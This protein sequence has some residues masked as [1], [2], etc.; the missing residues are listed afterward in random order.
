VT[1]TKGSTADS[2]TKLRVNL[3]AAGYSP[4]PA[5]GKSTNVAGW[6]KKTGASP[7][8]IT[9]W[10]K[11]YADHNNTGLI[12]THTP[13]LDIDIKDEAAAAAV[14]A[15]VRVRYGHRDKVLVR[16]GQAPKLLIPFQ[17]SATF[18][19]ITASVI[20][21]DGDTGQKIE[22]L[23]EG[24]MFVA[25]GTH[26]DTGAPYQW[27][28]GEPGSVKC[29]ELPEITQVQARQLVD[30]VV[31]LLCDKFGYSS[32]RPKKNN[33]VNEAA[34]GVAGWSELL[35]SIR[36]GHE[37]HD[38]T[39]DLAAKLVRSGMIGGAAVNVLRSLMDAS[40]APHDKRWQE[41]YD[42]I[43]RSVSSAEKKFKQDAANELTVEPHVFPDEAS[44]ERW[45]FLYDKHLL[46]KTVSGTAAMG[47]TGKSSL[48]MVEALALASGKELLGLKVPRQSRVLLINLEDT[49]NAMD[50]RIA[51]AMKHHGLTVEDI[52]GRLFTKAKGE[53]AFKIAEQSGAGSITP[54][55]VFID[56]LLGIVKSN[57]IDVI[58]ID[59][60]VST[61]AVNENDNSAIRDV[62]ECY[63]H[64]AERGNCAVHLWHHTR[65][66]NGLGAS[67]DS[68]RGASSFVDAC[69]SVRILETMTAD[70]GKR[71]KIENYRR[72][73]RAF[74][75]KLNFAPPIEKSDWF[76]LRSVPVLNGDCDPRYV[77]ADGGNGG[78]DVG[79]VEK[80]SLP[81]AAPL[82]LEN[83]EAIKK[84]VADG[85][86][87]EN[88]RAD[89]WVG[90]AVAPI[91]GL[92]P[93]LNRRDIT[94]VIGKLIFEKVL[95]TIPG[96]TKDRKDCLFVVPGDWSA[97]VVEL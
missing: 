15:L 87:R 2:L 60:F 51:A 77:Q 93:E 56:K 54:N 50:K 97:L 7:D 46:R 41:R 20:A 88:V 34:G 45:D 1:A 27:H 76:H 8:V 67:V 78:D 5:K 22:F 82:S 75:G 33:F 30:D 85:V 58:S 59:P 28:G 65:K 43:P 47:A 71:L 53:I 63:D 19:K 40:D 10:T 69:R 26:P 35:A 24:Q 49:R 21:P 96:K 16:V 72:Y 55:N 44:I 29:D 95:K 38:S 89:M 48:A 61:H 32:D 70:E 9:R 11:R 36:E 25:F 81:E 57:N 86:W 23:A 64:I 37:L 73:F 39:R 92:D 90:K 91:L 4:I 66:G 12:T 18:K 83:K 79:V 62:I 68:A 94:Q 31:Q 14:E 42:D 80:W 13:G 3:R 74:S 52:G 84:A 17:A 6:Q